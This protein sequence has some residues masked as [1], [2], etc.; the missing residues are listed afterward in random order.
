MK[1]INSLRIFIFDDDPSI[2][3]L[4]S[5]VLSDKGHDVQT[6]HD[7]TYCHIYP[8][9]RCE[10]P[11][12]YPCADVIISDIMMPNMNGIDQLRLQRDMGCKA[13]AKNKAL[14][15]AKSDSAR[16][17]AVEELGCHFIRKPFRLDDICKWVEEC[18][19]RL[20]KNRQLAPF[21]PDNQITRSAT[22]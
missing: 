1:Q 13:P 17:A 11:Q 2:T 7:P 18:A 20:P 6:F 3:R 19:E 9:N 21:K 14:M 22:V 5:L 15:S 12:D 8:D 10:C 16:I 4:L